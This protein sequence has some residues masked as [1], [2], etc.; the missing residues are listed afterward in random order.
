MAHMGH[1]PLCDPP[2]CFAQFCHYFVRYLH[3]DVIVDLDK[4]WENTREISLTTHADPRCT[5]SCIAITTAVSVS[6]CMSLCLVVHYRVLLY[7]TVSY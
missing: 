2:I 6:Y 1:S 7:V 3:G 5:A 4:V